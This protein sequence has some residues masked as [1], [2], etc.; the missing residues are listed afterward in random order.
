MHNRLYKFSDD[1]QGA[2]ILNSV[3]FALLIITP[4]SAQGSEAGADGKGITLDEMRLHRCCH[5]GDLQQQCHKAGGGLATSLI[6]VI[7]AR[8]EVAHY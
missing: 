7:A 2:V 5:P 6:N 1:T 8:S 3:G 4:F